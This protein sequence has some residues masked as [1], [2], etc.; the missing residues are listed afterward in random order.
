MHS[1][2]RVNPEAVGK[3]NVFDMI[4]YALIC[5]IKLMLLV[6]G[7]SKKMKLAFCERLGKANSNDQKICTSKSHN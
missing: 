7:K 3:D 1:L 5:I 2:D 4:S 6:L